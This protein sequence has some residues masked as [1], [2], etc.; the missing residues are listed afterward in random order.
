M[1]G[2][3]L[4]L[5]SCPADNRELK[6]ISIG[7]N[8]LLVEIADTPETRAAGLMHRKDL[9]SDRGMLFIFEQEQRMSFWMKNTHIPLSI[10]YISKAGEIKEIYDMTPLSEKPVPSRHSVLYALE[11]NKGYFEEKGIAPGDRVQFSF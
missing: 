1:L 8:T 3:L 6:E 5:V 11:V 7:D 9:P 10:A 2:A 4:L